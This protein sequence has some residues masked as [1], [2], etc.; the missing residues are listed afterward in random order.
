M[1][2][3]ALAVTPGLGPCSASYDSPACA[4]RDKERIAKLLRARAV[5][6]LPPPYANAE[7]VNDELL[8][9][10]I[11]PADHEGAVDVFVA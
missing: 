4:C 6:G 7:A 8:D 2:L 3:L 11:R 5:T 9:L 10:L 1:S